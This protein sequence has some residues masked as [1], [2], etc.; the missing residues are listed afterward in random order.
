MS[1]LQELSNSGLAIWLDDLSRERLESGSLAQLIASSHVVGVTTNPSI[2]SSAISKSEKYSADIKSL[3]ADGASIAQIVTRLTTDDVRAACDLF[4]DTY[5]ASSGVDGRVSIEVEPD[6]AYDTQGTI[7]RAL[8]LHE[9]VNRPNV[10]IKVPATIAGLPAIEE[11]TARGISINVTLIFSVER[12][13]AV[14]DAYLRGLERRLGNGLPLSDI[15]SVASFFV[16]RIDTE[17][18]KQLDDHHPGSELRGT[19]A[20]ANAHLAYEAFLNTTRS[21]RWK[22]LAAKGANYQR[23]LWASTGVKDKSYNTTRYVVELVAANTV[24]TMPEGTL[25]EVRAHGIVRGDTI[26]S[27][28][29]AAHVIFK[30]LAEAGVDIDH[31]TAALEDAAVFGFQKAWN[32]LLANVAAVIG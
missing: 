18:D 16:S 12:Y 4:L 3:S 20:I 26:T 1:A 31:I 2:F 9:I 6:L 27:E 22:S 15:H 14:S 24:N 7:A 25:D 19:A 13:V 23:P 32:E 5:Q 17:V 8:A 30:S 10:L 11:L 28:I 29:P 21:Q